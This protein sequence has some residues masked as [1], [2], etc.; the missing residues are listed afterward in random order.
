MLKH[1]YKWFKKPHKFDILDNWL[2]KTNIKILDVGCGNNSASKTK[3]Y[4]PSSIY[5]GLD[6]SKNYNN[7]N[8]DFEQ[9]KR[10]FQIDLAIDDKLSDL[11]NNYFDCII[12]SHIIEHLDNGDKVINSLIKKLKHNGIIYIEFPSPHSVRLPSMKGTLNFYDDPSHVR[13]YKVNEIN[14]LIKKDCVILKSGIKTSWKRIVFFPFY[15]IRAIALRNAL[16]GVF[17]DLT[18]FSSF[19]LAMKV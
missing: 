11:P 4:Y 12:L 17:W 15:L 2:K 14:T 16:G 19:V 18:G 8:D 7:E 6:Q 1:L 5:Y 9:M 10:F 13:I 3:M